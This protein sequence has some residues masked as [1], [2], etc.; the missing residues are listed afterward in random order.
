M[1]ASLQFLVL[2]WVICLQRSLRYAYLLLTSACSCD[3]SFLQDRRY[4]ESQIYAGFTQISIFVQIFVLGPR[5]ILGVRECS[6]EFAAE[7]D[8]TT[9]L[10]SIAFQEH[11]CI[12]TSSSV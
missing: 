12:E 5:L 1:Q 6:A 3:P 11:L 10:T 9:V 8:T 2:K 4:L 7:V